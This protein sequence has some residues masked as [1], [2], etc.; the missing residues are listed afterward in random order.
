MNPQLLLVLGAVL[1]VAIAAL[2]DSGPP[3]KPTGAARIRSRAR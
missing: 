1:L 2:L 3:A